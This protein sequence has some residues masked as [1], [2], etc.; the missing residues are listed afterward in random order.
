MSYLAGGM[1]GA[2]IGLGWVDQT[3]Q[4]HFQVYTKLSF[5]LSTDTISYVCLFVGSI[6]I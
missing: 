5:L 2:D 4:V 6:C 1:K 3:G